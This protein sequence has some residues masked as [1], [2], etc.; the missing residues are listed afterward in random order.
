MVKVFLGVGHGGN[1]PGA[2]ANGFLEKDLNLAIALSCFAELSRHGIQVLMSRTKDENDTLTEEIEECN[3]FNPALAIDIHNNAGGGDGV[4]VF[5]HHGG[6]TGKVLAENVL[7]QI[8]SLGQQSRGT[9]IKL[10][11]DGRDWYGFIRETACPAVIVECAFVDNAADLAFVNTP[12]KQKAV[13]IAL[14]KGILQTLGIPWQEETS[15]NTETEKPN[16]ESKPEETMPEIQ[17]KKPI[18]PSKEPS[19]SENAILNGIFE[20]LKKIILRFFRWLWSKI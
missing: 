5:H 2:V 16:P 18:A 4:E 19:D 6:G 7:S 13:G 17:E 12:E 9:K 15:K 8:V 14:A 10:N 3:A 11:G 1:D 20:F